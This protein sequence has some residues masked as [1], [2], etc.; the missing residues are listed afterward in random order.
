MIDDIFLI[1]GSFVILVTIG[2][3]I[4]AIIARK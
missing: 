3:I 1:Y 2:V 4:Y